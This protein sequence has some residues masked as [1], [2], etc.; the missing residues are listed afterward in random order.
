LLFGGA[1]AE[2]FIFPA[3]MYRQAA[4]IFLAIIIWQTGISWLAWRWIHRPRGMRAE[5]T[6]GGFFIAVLAVYH[7]SHAWAD[8]VGYSDIVEQD[9]LLP[10]RHALTAKGLL[11]DLGINVQNASVQR[12][13]I[14]DDSLAYPQKEM[15][16][17]KPDSPRNIIFIMIDSWRFDAMTPPVTPHIHRF[18][19]RT[20][21]FTEHYSG[22][23]ATRVGV[24]SLFYAIPGTYWHSMLDANQS[25]VF[26]DE[27]MRQGYDV[28]VFR[29]APLIARNFIARFSLEYRMPVCARMALSRPIGTEI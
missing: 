28:E 10:V 19:A 7:L 22:G 24:F 3:S 13:H 18:S 2:T 25:P 9:E 26:I 11:K 21:Q 1:A 23:N 17:Q 15:A 29:S 6:V 4:L 20:S 14:T 27:L 16:C 5:A 12:S 8:G